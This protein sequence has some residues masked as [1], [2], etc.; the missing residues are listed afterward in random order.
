MGGEISPLERQ[1]MKNIE[2]KNVPFVFQG[3]DDNFSY[4]DIISMLMQTPEDI[5]KGAG[6]AEIRNSLRVLDALEK[7]DKELIL[8]DADFDYLH[9]RVNNMKFAGSHRVFIDFVDYFEELSK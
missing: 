4:R 1:R 6:I 2:L 3:Q 8:E 5:Q 9:R 7:D